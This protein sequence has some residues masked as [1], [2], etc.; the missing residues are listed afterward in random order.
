M[1][2]L[3]QTMRKL[4]RQGIPFAFVTI[5][6]GSGSM[7]RHK[8]SKMIVMDDGTI[9]G[10]IGGGQLEADAIRWAATALH[11]KTDR[12]YRFALDNEH[13]AESEMICGGSGVISVQYIDADQEITPLL[14]A[15]NTGTMYLFG[16]GHVSLALAQAAKIAD[17]PTVVL[18]DREEYANT[19][20]FPDTACIV[21]DSF[22]SIPAL[23]VTQKDMLVIVTRGHL[24]DADVL[25]WALQQNAGYIGMIG[26][27]RKRDMLYNM[28]RQEGMSEERLAQVHS[29][30]GLPIGAETPGEIAI[31]IMAEII[32]VRAKGDVK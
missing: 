2:Q 29:P 21:L 19:N 25:R 17:I 16:G 31:S 28:M 32:R 10:S 5:K 9:A 15:C 27:K 20:R 26:S 11:D 4:H 13:A 22:S 6:E 18:D 3:N 12:D 7:P 8:G 24:G 14:D 1:T 30:I 23:P